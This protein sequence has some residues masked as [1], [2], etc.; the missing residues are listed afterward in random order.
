MS[1]FTFE[2]CSSKKKKQFVFFD[3]HHKGKKEVEMLDWGGGRGRTTMTLFR[4]KKKRLSSRWK[5]INCIEQKGE[6][7]LEREGSDGRPPHES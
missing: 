4:Q 2:G 1:F 3:L 7:P 6:G 5:S